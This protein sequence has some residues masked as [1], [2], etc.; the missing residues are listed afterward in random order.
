MVNNMIYPPKRVMVEKPSM[1]QASS[2]GKFS[3]CV[4]ACF[5]VE[6]VEEISK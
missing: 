3:R 5:F 4:G 2:I 6:P 1:M